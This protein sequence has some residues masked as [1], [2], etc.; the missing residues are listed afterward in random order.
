MS[1]RLTIILKKKI[2]AEREF[3]LGSSVMGEWHCFSDAWGN[4]RKVN[5]VVD[6][7]RLGRLRRLNLLAGCRV[8]AY[9]VD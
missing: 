9:S 4:P 2:N 6:W 3:A 1:E 5:S 8:T 7:I